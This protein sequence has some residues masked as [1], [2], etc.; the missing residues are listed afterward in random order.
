MS[1][2]SQQRPA[3]VVEVVDLL[4]ELTDRVKAQFAVVTGA[5]ELQVPQARTLLRI[6]G[7]VSMRD[8]AARLRCD[9][10]NMTGIIDGLHARGLVERNPLPNDRRVKQV[11]LTEEGKRLQTRLRQRL[12]VDVPVLGKLD[13]TQRQELHAILLRVVER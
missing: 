12:A 13:D 6:N 10:S 4:F 3:P 11:V 9:A 1:P 5:L 2:G 7:P 8:L